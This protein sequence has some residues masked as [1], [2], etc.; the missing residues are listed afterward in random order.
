MLENITQDDNGNYTCRMKNKQGYFTKKE[1][2]IVNPFSCTTC[3]TEPHGK[4][5]HSFN[6]RMQSLLLLLY[7]THIF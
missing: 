4:C 6:K 2:L 3:V 1:L 5:Y 7:E